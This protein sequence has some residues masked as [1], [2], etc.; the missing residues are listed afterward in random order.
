MALPEPYY[1]ADG[2]TIYC[3][4][5]RE[6][7]PQLTADLVLTDPPYGFRKADWDASAPTWWREDAARVAPRLGVMPGVWNLPDWPRRIGRLEYKW[8]LAAFLTNGMTRATVGFGNWIPCLVYTADGATAYQQQGDSRAFAVGTEG[9]PDHPSP[10]PLRVMT[11][12]LG[13]IGG[14][15]VIDPFMGSGTTLVGAK[16]LGRRAIGIE[17]EEKYCEIAVQRLAQ[18]VLPLGEG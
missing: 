5:S 6:I 8:T 4:D 9:K 2:I 1:E 10:K 12:L 11:W 14:E 15:S 17:I 13:R 16:L 3:G 18:G 7:L